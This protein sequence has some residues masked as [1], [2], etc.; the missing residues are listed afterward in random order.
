MACAPT[1]NASVLRTSTAE[2]LGS[3][4]A[5]CRASYVHPEIPEAYQDGRLKDAWE[6]SRRGTWLSRAESVGR[7]LLENNGT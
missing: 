1:M 3:T 2:T 4:R 5:V 7:K 6:K